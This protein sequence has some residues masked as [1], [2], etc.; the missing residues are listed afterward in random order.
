[1]FLWDFDKMKKYQSESKEF[2]KTPKCGI[3]QHYEKFDLGTIFNCFVKKW[4]NDDA[5]EILY[6]KG[7]SKIIWNLD[8]EGAQNMFLT[9]L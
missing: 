7:W 2:D 5:W 9:P 4:K 6:T 1:L 8:F 3:V